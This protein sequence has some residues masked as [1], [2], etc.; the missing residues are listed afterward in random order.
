M[1]YRVEMVIDKEVYEYGTYENKNKANEVALMLRD[2]ETDT[3]VV[4]I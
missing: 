3:R 4:E 1:M 2:D